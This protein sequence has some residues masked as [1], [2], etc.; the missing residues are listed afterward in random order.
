MTGKEKSARLSNIAREALK[1]SALMSDVIL[2]ELQKDE[3]NV[4]CPFNGYYWSLSHKP[5]LVAAV[6]SK[7]KIGI[8]IEEVMPRHESVFLRTAC[9]AE[10]ALSGDRSWI[11]FFRYWTAKE[12]VLK[13]AGTGITELKACHV[14][15]VPD[16]SHMVLRYQDRCF[17]VEQLYYSNHIVSVINEDDDI[18]WNIIKDSVHL[19]NV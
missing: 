5:E 9:E 3:N 2:G 1:L 16:E 8:D 15:S 17:T 12:A 14:I 10:W 19:R 7:Q 18:Q 13:A 6:V 4:P 11:T